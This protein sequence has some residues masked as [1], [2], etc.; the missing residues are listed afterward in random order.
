MKRIQLASFLSLLTFSLCSAPVNAQT[1]TPTS[2]PEASTATLVGEGIYGDVDKYRRDPLVSVGVVH[3]NSVVSLRVD[4]SVADTDYEKY[5]IQFNFFVNRK[6]FSSQIRSK[7]LPGAIGIDVPNTVAAAPFNYTI[8]ATVLHPNRQFTT[9]IE[10]AI[11]GNNL[12]A[13]LDCT[14]TLPADSD[15]TPAPGDEPE[16]YTENNVTTSQT[17]ENTFSLSL[18]KAQD[19]ANS[20]SVSLAAPVTVN[21]ADNTASATLAIT[22]DGSQSSVTATGKITITAGNLA[23]LN[24]TSSDGETILACS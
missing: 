7:A 15:A 14:L 17:G 20:E 12:V 4:A 6:L 19:A 9:I 16:I 5:P 3:G 1:P 8:V 22:R 24:V 18:N 10:G 2:A 11:F 13:T 23:S 21:L